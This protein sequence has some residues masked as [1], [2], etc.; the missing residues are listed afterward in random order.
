MESLAKTRMIF[1]A[2]TSAEIILLNP[3]PPWPEWN[4]IDFHFAV[5]ADKYFHPRILENMGAAEKLGK[6]K[7]KSYL[8]ERKAIMENVLDKLVVKDDVEK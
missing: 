3:P 6:R 7:G 4:H 8:N 2:K 5:D 1:Q